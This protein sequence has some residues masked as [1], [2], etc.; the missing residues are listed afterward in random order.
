MTKLN[1]TKQTKNNNNDNDEKKETNK[2]KQNKGH[3]RRETKQKH[4]D[5]AHNHQHKSCLALE[6][7]APRRANRNSMDLPSSTCSTNLLCM[8]ALCKAYTPKAMRT[9]S[10]AES[11]ACN[12]KNASLDLKAGVCAR[13]R[14]CRRLLS[15]HEMACYTLC[16]GRT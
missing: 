16:I 1:A 12:K 5:D 7:S 10:S 3:K 9:V 6:W 14:K 4:N 11:S 15:Q 13:L 8:T 2:N